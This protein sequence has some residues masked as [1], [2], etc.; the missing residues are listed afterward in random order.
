MSAF[1][2]EELNLADQEIRREYE[3]TFH[4]C[5]V[6][7]TSNRLIHQLWVWDY[8]AGRVAV[9]IP[10]DQQIVLGVRDSV[11]RLDT[12]MAFNVGMQELQSAAFA[13]AVPHAGR[14]FEILTF[15]SR[16]DRTLKMKLA[17]WRRCLEEMQ[18]RGY[19]D[20]YATTARR[21]LASYRRLGWR[22]I[23]ETSL[24]GEQRYFLHYDLALSGARW[25]AAEWHSAPPNRVKIRGGRI[26]SV[27]KLPACPTTPAI[28]LQISAHN[29]AICSEP[30]PPS[31][32]SA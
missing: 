24:A 20:G 22:V 14:S 25:L 1:R 13:F 9:R 12:A 7:V 6:Q 5:F 31:R 19:R 18:A 15:F 3:S 23:D 8:A 11:G 28:P 30:I 10:Y 27:R 2:F 16:S 29:R 26:P 4:D 21:P 17:F 32:S